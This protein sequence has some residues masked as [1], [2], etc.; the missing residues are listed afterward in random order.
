[1]FT[2]WVLFSLIVNICTCFRWNMTWGVVVRLL[3]SVGGGRLRGICSQ[4]RHQLLRFSV[5]CRRLAQLASRPTVSAAAVNI[6][7]TKVTRLSNGMRVASE[8]SGIPTTTVGLWIDAGSRFETGKSNGVAHFLEHMAFKVASQSSPYHD[9]GS[10]LRIAL[11]GKP[12]AKRHSYT[13]APDSDR[14][15]Q[16]GATWGTTL[17]DVLRVERTSSA[18]CLAIYCKHFGTFRA[19]LAVKMWL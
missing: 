2:F 12:V 11:Y 19:S 18:I 16:W 8:D 9:G 4:R 14:L 5:S 13:F 3:S 17:F 6:P 1:L 15:S 7:E 10:R